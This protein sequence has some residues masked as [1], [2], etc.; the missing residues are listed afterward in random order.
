VTPWFYHR[1]VVRRLSTVQL[2]S[3]AAASVE[4]IDLLTEIGVLTRQPGGWYGAGDLIRLEAVNAFLAA[5][6]HL[7]QMEAALSEGIF[8]FEY[9]DRFHPEPGPFS[10]RTFQEFADK[11]EVSP[12]LIESIYLAM[13]LPEP[14]SDKPMR[15]DEEGLVEG[16]LEAWKIGSDVETYLRAARL[17]G[18]PARQVSEGWTRL[19]V[20]KVSDPLVGQEMPLKEQIAM[21][22]ESTERLTRLAPPLLIWLFDRHLRNAID[23][24]NIDGLEQQL[25]AHGLS[26][27]IPGRPPAVAFVDIS[28]YTS[29]TE[30]HGDDVATATADRLRE[31]AER[32]ARSHGGT[33]VKL[34]GDGVMLHFTTVDGGLA[35]VVDLVDRLAAGELQA[36][37]GIHAGPMIEHDRDY[38]GRTVNLAARV[39]GVAGAGEVVVTEAVVSAVESDAYVFEQLAPVTLKG[40]AEPVGIFR[41]KLKSS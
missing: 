21:I 30:A 28:G 31:L 7:E 26:L 25:V 11:L 1:R 41:V 27:P 3:E 37:A 32:S 38:F 2:A 39:T 29:L 17:I 18:E 36:H 40:I 15:L 20:E 5:G 24:A 8:T 19:Y 34:L 16:F 10:G 12:D 23:R 4:L 14:A 33:V 9:L 22:V 13:G 35:G 6:V